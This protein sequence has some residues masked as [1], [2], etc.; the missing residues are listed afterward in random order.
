MK[1]KKPFYKQKRYLIPV[2]FLLLIIVTR[3][4]LPTYVKNYVNKVLSDLPGYYGQVESIDISL[5]RGAYT[6]N[7]LY[8]NE[9]DDNSQIPFLDF[10]KTD[11]SIQWKSLLKGK[12]VSEIEMESPSVIYVFEDQKTTA[13][14]EAEVEDWT[15]ALTN[16]VPID[17]NRLYVTNGKAAFVQLAANPN[18]DLQLNNI[19][20]EAANL[21]NVVR[22]G[23]KLPSSLKA[24]ATSIGNGKV[25]LTGKM[26]ILKEIPDMDISFSLKEAEATSLNDFTKHYAGI[27]FNSGTY[28]V[29]SEI[30]IA[31]GYLKGYIKPILKDAKLLGKEDGFLNGIWEGFVG[32]FKLILKNQKQNSLATNVPLEGDLNN[33]KTKIWPTVLNIFKNAWVKSYKEVTDN[34]INFKDALQAENQ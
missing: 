23:D 16:L 31:N 12:I 33:V 19:T 34:K 11:I 5:I 24:T 10:K 1:N 20:L 15:K 6:I 4:I 13:A 7:N 32:F 22:E 8:L 2:V 27:D 29:F 30:A 26:D 17:I 3:I 21:R 14:N 28:G 18:I 25:H 9:V